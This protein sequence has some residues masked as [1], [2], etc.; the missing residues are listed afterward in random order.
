MQYMAQAGEG[1]GRKSN[2]ESLIEARLGY[3]WGYNE[4]RFRDGNNALI[5]PGKIVVQLDGPVVGLMAG[6]A[7]S[8]FGV[9]AQAWVNVP[10]ELRTDFYLN[11]LQQAWD[12]LPQYI[13]AD[14]S[15]IYQLG[16]R[17]IPYTAGLVGGYRY[18]QFHY[19]SRRGPTPAGSYQNHFHVQIPYLGIYY[20]HNNL[21]GSAVRLDVLAS[22]ITLARID[23]K[24]FADGFQLRS[25]GTSFMGQMYELVF[26]FSRKVSD[27][28]LLGA[29]VKGYYLE[30]DAG[31][32]V[33][34]SPPP[35]LSAVQTAFS[36]DSRHS[37]IIL[38]LSGDYSF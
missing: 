2:R 10:Q 5:P 31:A 32:T 18:D 27:N 14:V 6:T 21:L 13:E 36:L 12:T 17:G 7:S 38:G 15:L 37:I 25:D 11:G 34:K 16:L 23:G 33:T 22:P 26:E 29:F 20:A 4:I 8:D 9:R 30:L 19:D 28:V 3:L 35:N 24:E 1:W